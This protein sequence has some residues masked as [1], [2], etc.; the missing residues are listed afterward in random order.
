[1]K[2]FVGVDYHKHYSYGV[3]M[4]QDRRILKQ[5]RF[6]NHPRAVSEFLGPHGGE[7]CHAVLE[8]TRGWT[9]MHDWLEAQAGE[10]VLAHPMK[11][12]A[13][14]E[15]RIKTDKIDATTL[16]ELLRCDLIPRSHV[17]SPQARLIQRL[18]RHRLFLVRIR[19]MCKNRIHDLLDRHPLLRAQWP[20]EELFSKVGM[21][22]MRSVAVPETDRFIL[23]SELDSLEH[24]AVQIQRAEKRLA[25]V[26][27][28]DPRVAW[29]QTIPGIGP[30]FSMLLIS[31]IDDV[32]RFAAPAKLHAYAGL[33][34]STHSSGGRTYHG[35]TIK[36]S[37][38]Y[39][40]W[41]MVEAVWPAIRQDVDLYQYYH[42]LARRKGANTAK[43]ATARRLLSLVYR[44]WKEQR[45]YIPS[46]SA[47]RPSA[48]SV[49]A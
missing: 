15:A 40:R 45:A 18:L 7:Q 3:I 44:V 41:A 27:H 34:P 36:G 24:L 49:C 31:E 42:R 2:T 12:K 5:G 16:A 8:A 11:L 19:T 20:S 39:L 28:A 4:T 32:A 13:I 26:G 33:I 38:K 9:V 17:R 48:G 10:V 6:A 23:D 25:R 46:P 30:F 47:H 37:N 14:A 21:A 43:V 29:L 1:M 22:W 35:R